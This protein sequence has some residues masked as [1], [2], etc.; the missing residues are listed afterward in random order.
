MTGWE[1]DPGRW[2]IKQSPQAAA[3]A[4]PSNATTRIESFERSRS[5]DV[6]FAPRTTTALELT[7]KQKGIPYWMRP[8]LGIDPEDIKI[9]GN[10]IAVTVHSLGAVDSPSA[11]VVLRDRNGLTL[12]TASTPTLKAPIDLQP[13]V[14]IVSLQ[15]PSKAI[16]EGGSIT[17]ES[18]GRVPEITQ[19]NNTVQLT[20][21]LVVASA[22]APSQRVRVKK[23]H[24]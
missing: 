15:L 6:T 24:E 4:P 10:R 13:K 7:L 18:S 9:E 5:L 23:N 11:Q 14:A 2:E 21:S 22:N 12:A 20:P 16:L 1:I 3:D 19:M 8:D 17:I